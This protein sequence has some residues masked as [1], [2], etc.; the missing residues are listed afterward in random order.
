MGDRVNVQIVDG[1]KRVNLYS[2]WGGSDM[3]ETVRVALAKRQRWTDGAYLARIIFCT[4]IAGDVD[5]ETGFGIS[6]PDALPDNE[7]PLIIVSAD[8]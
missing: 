7:H 2:H 5:G 6:P 3:P 8:D 1:G 4:M